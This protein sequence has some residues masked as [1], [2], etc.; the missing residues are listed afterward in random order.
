MSR[1]KSCAVLRQGKKYDRLLLNVL[2]GRRRGEETISL[3]LKIPACFVTVPYTPTNQVFSCFQLIVFT[4]TQKSLKDISNNRVFYTV[5]TCA[6][7]ICPKMIFS[8]SLVSIPV[9]QLREHWEDTSDKVLSRRNQLEDLQAEHGRFEARRR[10]AEAWLAR[11]EAWAGRIEKE[12]G[13]G[14][15]EQAVS[16]AL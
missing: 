7:L 9:T 16:E 5:L 13:G 15:K 11:M 10:E 6:S 3:V 12:E 4:N 14:G 8:I 2:G 1:G